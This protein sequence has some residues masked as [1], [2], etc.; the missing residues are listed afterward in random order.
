MAEGGNLD[1]FLF[2]GTTGTA[3]NRLPPN[4]VNGETSDSAANALSKSKY[5]SPLELKSYRFNYRMDDNWAEELGGGQ[6]K[7]RHKPQWGPL[8]FTKHFD[9]AS[10]GL[11]IALN[12]ASV[13]EEVM[14]IHRRAGG[15]SG[16]QTFFTAVM[17]K[18]VVQSLDWDANDAGVLIETAN[19]EYS[20]ISV[21]YVAQH[22]KGHN[23]TD[24]AARASGQ[25]DFPKNARS[26]L[27]SMGG[28]N[29]NQLKNWIDDV[30]KYCNKDWDNYS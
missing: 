18:V 5:G 19:L 9:K 7:F 15:K 24:N 28:I 1:A 30:S 23:D 8:Y 22:A 21:E 10:P 16:Q 12:Q 6:A 20:Q 13:F 2:F 26:K 29:E 4:G 25:I 27:S 11:F 14:L 17:K 3:D